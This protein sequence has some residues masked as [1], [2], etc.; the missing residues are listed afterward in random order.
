MPCALHHFGIGQETAC[1]CLRLHVRKRT[2]SPSHLFQGF[3]FLFWSQRFHF[4]FNTSFL[5]RAC[6]SGIKDF[7]PTA[8]IKRQIFSITCIKI[9]K[10]LVQKGV[11]LSRK[12]KFSKFYNSCQASEHY[13]RIRQSCGDKA[14][15]DGKRLYIA[16]HE[17]QH[18]FMWFMDTWRADHSCS[19]PSG[20]RI[21]SC[22]TFNAAL[23]FSTSA[24][25]SCIAGL[26]SKLAFL[27]ERPPTGLGVVGLAV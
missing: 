27:S 7:L 23:Q 25:V 4:F 15:R 12:N 22:S 24:G 13:P 10:L 8:S 26:S 18:Q 19:M 17:D 11:F 9:S 21:L 5:I 2:P 6:R 3:K 1:N 14:L 16:H 20:T